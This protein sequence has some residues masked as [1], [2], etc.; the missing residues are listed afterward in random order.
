V[1]WTNNVITNH[2]LS[3]SSARPTKMEHQFDYG[4][5]VWIGCNPMPQA[6]L[7]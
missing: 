7:S 6:P 5:V 4:T 1:A 3:M 2:K